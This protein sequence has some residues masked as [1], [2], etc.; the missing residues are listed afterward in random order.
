MDQ[1]Y[2]MKHFI[3]TIYFSVLLCYTPAMY[4]ASNSE[5]INNRQLI[6]GYL[7][8]TH[9]ENVLYEYV[10]MLYTYQENTLSTFIQNDSLFATESSKLFY[11]HF[12]I[13]SLYMNI[14][15][16]LE[17]LEK[18]VIE[19]FQLLSEYLNTNTGK[20]ML[21]Y[22]TLASQ[23][24]ELAKLPIYMKS[25]KEIP[26]SKSR[27]RLVHRLDKA[28]EGSRISARMTM[29]F[30]E[31]ILIAINNAL[32]E[33]EQ[34]HTNAIDELI[35]THYKKNLPEFQ[36]AMQSAYLFT[37]RVVSDSELE[38]Y[39]EQYEYRS[40]KLASLSLASTLIEVFQEAG[41]SFAHDLT[42]A[43]DKH[44]VKMTR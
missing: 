23:P 7:G 40:T 26:P 39:V 4:S 13:S 2:F 30:L 36:L 5:A 21:Y 28:I 10:T 14:L 38:K 15:D 8:A 17:L 6:S 41:F 33:K 12:N 32:P 20:R 25:L 43:L 3:F 37:Y 42:K 16:K 29:D 44:R 19:G 27:I 35:Q 24:S 22:E 1:I 34:T 31:N 18:E 11:K 9:F